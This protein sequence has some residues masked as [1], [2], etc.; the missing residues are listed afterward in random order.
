MTVPLLTDIMMDRESMNNIFKI[1]FTNNQDLY[2]NDKIMQI[3]DRFIPE[4]TG[5]YFTN[6]QGE[7]YKLDNDGGFHK[8][9]VENNNDWYQIVVEQNKYSKMD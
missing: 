6:K 4:N 1:M 7:L 3:S 8:I 9:I 2:L 5:E